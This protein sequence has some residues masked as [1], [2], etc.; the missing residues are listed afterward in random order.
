MVAYVCR[1]VIVV[2]VKPFDRKVDDCFLSFPFFR[3]DSQALPLPATFV[4]GAQG[5]R[6]GYHCYGLEKTRPACY[7]PSIGVG[8]LGEA[9]GS[10]FPFRSI[11][12][13]TAVNRKF[14]W[15]CDARDR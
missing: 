15:L 3:V 5:G 1:C 8:E 2:V 9:G 4:Y 14:R 12:E 10:S 13:D 6:I 11:G 7:V